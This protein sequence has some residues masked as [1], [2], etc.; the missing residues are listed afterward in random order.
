[1]DQSSKG[2]KGWEIRFFAFLWWLLILNHLVYSSWCT[3]CNLYHQTALYSSICWKS[4]WG[5][6]RIFVQNLF[7]YFDQEML[8]NEASN[9]TVHFICLLRMKPW[10]VFSK[11]K[12]FN[13]CLALFSRHQIKFIQNFME[14]WLPYRN[15]LHL[16]QSL[17]MRIIET[18]F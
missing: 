1:M 14:A 5:S 10:L 16:N 8:V 7:S 13:A 18:K 2:I 4:F 11:R 3:F 9:Q 15:D 12:S 17:R 6:L